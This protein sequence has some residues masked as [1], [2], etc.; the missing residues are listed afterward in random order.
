M[1]LLMKNSKYIEDNVIQTPIRDVSIDTE[2]QNQDHKEPTT[3]T[4]NICNNRGEMRLMLVT[5]SR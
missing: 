4:K 1:H 2:D 3:T 5:E